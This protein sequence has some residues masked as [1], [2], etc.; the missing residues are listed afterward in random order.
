MFNVGAGELLGILA[1]A[2]IVLGPE[3]L[4]GAV[5]QVGRAVGEVRRVVA[6][7]QDELMSADTAEAAQTPGPD[8]EPD[9]PPAGDHA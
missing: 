2:L 1:L 7:F 4:P 6:G 8:P 5:R 9:R 3:R